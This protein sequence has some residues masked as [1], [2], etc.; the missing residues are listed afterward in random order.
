MSPM[1]MPR[2]P[3]SPALNPIPWSLRRPFETALRITKESHMR[4]TNIITNRYRFTSV[5]AAFAV[6]LGAGPSAQGNSQEGFSNG[7]RNVRV[8]GLTDDG[9]LV[10]FRA[11]APQATKTSA[12]SRVFPAATRRWSASTS[13]SRMGRCTV[14]ETAA[15]STRSTRRQPRHSSSTP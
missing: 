2:R 12:S 7:S 13:A 14:S 1:G 10:Q 11:N 5:A 15:V 6:L 8:I 9:R 3:A 4:T